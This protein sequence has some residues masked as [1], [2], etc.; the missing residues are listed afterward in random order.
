MTAFALVWADG[1]R[2]MHTEVAP[3]GETVIGRSSDSTIVLEASAVSRRHVALRRS[4]SGFVAENLSQTN[5]AEVNGQSIARGQVPLGDGDRLSVGG[6]EMTFHDLNATLRVSGPICSHCGRENTA[7]QKDC[8]YCGTSLVFASSRVRRRVHA[9]L[10]AISRGGE[11][12]DV[13][14]GEALRIAVD[15]A[16]E[17]VRTEELTDAFPAIE[18]RDG[19]AYLRPGGS[20]AVT[21]NGEQAGEA[22]QL[23][24]GDE[25]SIGE[26]RYVVLVA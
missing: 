17:V 18:A 26:A 1:D 6:V 11:R 5:P 15:D 7:T 21:F 14:P 3:D 24:S 19:A 16:P 4:G 23:R 13:Y 20:T 10:R 12:H 9:A 22:R 25:I 8:W 2:L